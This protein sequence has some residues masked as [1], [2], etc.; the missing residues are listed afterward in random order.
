[1]EQCASLLALEKSR[2]TKAWG[3][4]NARPM[5]PAGSGT[6]ATA[7]LLA[8]PPFT[9]CLRTTSEGLRVLQAN[10]SFVLYTESDATVLPPD[11]EENGTAIPFY[12]SVSELHPFN[13]CG[14]LGLRY[15]LRASTYL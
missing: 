12:S 11:G 5:S 7:V 9:I 13:P 3:Y 10:L 4:G 8:A 14:D 2:W 15:Q 1:M 6:P